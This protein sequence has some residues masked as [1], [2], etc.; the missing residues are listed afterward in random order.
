MVISE[1]VKISIYRVD[2]KKSLGEFMKEEKRG[3]PSYDKNNV[4]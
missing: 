1:M 4:L 3:D 2:S